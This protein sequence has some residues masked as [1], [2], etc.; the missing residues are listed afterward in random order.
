MSLICS[1]IAGGFPLS[2]SSVKNRL[3]S[4]DGMSFAEF[5]YPVLQSWDWWHMYHTKRVQ[6]Q[7]GGSDQM[8]NIIA[9]IDAIN[10]INKNHYDP[11]HRLDKD[12]L[13][14]R[15]MGF[16][17]PLLTTASGEKFGKSAGNAV[18]LDKDMTSAFDLYQVHRDNHYEKNLTNVDKFFIR[19][20]DADVG[21]YLK[22]FTFMPTH[23]INSLMAE[24]EQQPSKR[25]A[26]SK[27]AREVLEIIHGL[28]IANEAEAQHALLFRPKAVSMPSDIE[29][30]EHGLDADAITSKNGKPMDISSALNKYAIH[31]TAANAPSHN[32]ILPRSLVIHQ[33][34][35]RVLWSAGLV[36]SKSEGH[37][38]AAKKGAYIGSRPSASGTM[39]DHLDFSPCMNWNPA[40]TEKYLIGDDTLILRVGKWK[41][42]IV[43][44]ISDKEFEE[45]GLT[46][47]GW[48]EEDNEPL[49]NNLIKLKPWNQ[50]TYEKRVPLHRDNFR[51]TPDR[52]KSR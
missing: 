29:G 10:Y 26:Q 14:T 19:S 48:K 2:M 27:L 3:E 50:K 30:S 6:V 23:D 17:V 42:K 20:T 7:I 46:A 25:I 11:D 47:P 4:G 51:F 16:T 15:P 9:G 28:A 32:V 33:P 44:I 39:S 5:S 41:V 49:D 40:D 24:H 43:K 1:G 8:G 36:A 45:R 21:R 38:L 35:A 12:D 22:L 18:W 13:L 52:V 34:I 37:R 31:T